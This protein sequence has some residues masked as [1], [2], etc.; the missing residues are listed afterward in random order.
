LNLALN[1]TSIIGISSYPIV[2]EQAKGF[3]REVLDIPADDAYD[4]R[5]RCLTRALVF[6]TSE[7]L[8]GS[9]RR[10]WGLVTSLVRRDA[11][12][13]VTLRVQQRAW[14]VNAATCS[15]LREGFLG[16]LATEMFNATRVDPLMKPILLTCSP[17]A[18]CIGGNR[19]SRN[20]ESDFS[21]GPYAK[22]R[23]IG[24]LIVVSLTSLCH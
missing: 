21:G 4:Q 13:G 14:P 10:R 24:E 22:V 18:N 6:G 15:T 17:G 23:P 1:G 8:S 5:Y 9:W 20:S 16:H 2:V 12:G 7:R 19:H 11:F 3:L